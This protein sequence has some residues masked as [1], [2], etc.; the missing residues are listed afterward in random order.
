MFRMSTILNVKKKY[1]YFFVISLVISV[2][3]TFL[4]NN[5]LN[6]KKVFQQENTC[7]EK[8]L[9]LVFKYKEFW[10]SNQTS[11]LHKYVLFLID[12][13]LR[14]ISPKRHV[15]LKGEIIY[16]KDN[17]DIC[18]NFMST[19]DENFRTIS[20]NIMLKL[21]DLSSFIEGSGRL[22]FAVQDSLIFYSINEDF[23]YA[24]DMIGYKI[25]ENEIDNVAI[26]TINVIRFLIILLILNLIF[27][28]ANSVKI[29]IKD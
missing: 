9:K 28:M 25:L 8:S 6:S 10:K 20:E 24:E 29:K 13:E 23:L 14:R 21:E 7:Q 15:F 26:Q 18:K 19:L 12:Y 11:E 22:S 17:E 27:Y 2:I 3:L 1:F 5:Q 4:L 16:F